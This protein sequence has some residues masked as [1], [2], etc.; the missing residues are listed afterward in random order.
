MNKKEDVLF[1]LVG[2]ITVL[3]FAVSCNREELLTSTTMKA[4]QVTTTLE[5]VEPEVE[6]LD[7]TIVLSERLGMGD[8]IVYVNKVTF[9]DSINHRSGSTIIGN[10]ALD[11][12]IVVNIDLENRGSKELLLKNS[13]FKMFD[14]SGKEYFADVNAMFYFDESG[15]AFFSGIDSEESVSGDV[16]FD[17]TVSK[18]YYFE[19][20]LPSGIKKRVRIDH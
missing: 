9:S 15:L 2:V 7:E 19:I 20:S 10:K 14:S 11:T 5:S 13:N 6:P 4:E 12:F 16:V 3:L 18:R 17:V 8:V 1:L